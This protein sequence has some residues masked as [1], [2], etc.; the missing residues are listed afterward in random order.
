VAAG[1]Y[2]VIWA[3][4]SLSMATIPAYVLALVLMV[5]LG[6][7]LERLVYA[8]LRRRSELVILLATLGAGIVIQGLI[9]LW[10]GTDAH[11]VPSPARNHVIVIDG[12]SV[13]VQR[14]V[15][16]VVTLI[17]T[18]VLLWV[19]AKTA[20]GRQLRALAANRETAMLQGVNV[21]VLP[22]VAFVISAVMA[23]VAGILAA[24][25]GAVDPT[26]GFSLMLTGFAAAVLGGFGSLS[27]IV[28]AAMFLGLVQ[29]VGGGYLVPNY[30]DIL[31]FAVMLVL[32]AVRPAGFATAGGTRL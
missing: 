21:S 1:P 29:Q 22:A 12:A 10:Q 20:F 14:V 9:A 7:A 16:V 4:G 23:G 17:V 2:F 28:V 13:P 30:Q 3:V 31:P 19:F 8:P 15:M 6:L 18:G 5:P 25:L 24:P 32:I 26:F 11:S 27:G